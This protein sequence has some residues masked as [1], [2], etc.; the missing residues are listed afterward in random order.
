MVYNGGPMKIPPKYLVLT[1][2]FTA[3]TAAGAYIRIPFPLAPMTLQLLFVLMSGYM[4]GPSFGAL[5]QAMY[6]LIG[7]LGIP[8]FAYGGG[9]GYVFDPTFGFL[10]GFILCSYITGKIYRLRRNFTGAAAGGAAGIL[11]CYLIGLPYLYMV[12]NFHLGI[13]KTAGDVLFGAMIIFLPGDALKLFV[14]A[15]L[16]P[17]IMKRAGR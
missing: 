16:A 1:P 5:S 14:S 9:L 7:L 12:F 8:V 3:L 17:L 10:L 6:V 4:L 11:A 13:K 2:M 15:H